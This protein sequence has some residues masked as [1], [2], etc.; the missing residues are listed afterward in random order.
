M[1]DLI[2]TD[3]MASAQRVDVQEGISLVAL[4]ELHAGDLACGRAGGMQ[5]PGVSALWAT[6]S[7][8]WRVPLGSPLFNEVD[9][10]P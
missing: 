3:S 10:Y 9:G 2:S 8:G 5:R 6:G 4:E 7:N 1:L